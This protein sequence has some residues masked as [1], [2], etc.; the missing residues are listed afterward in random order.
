MKVVKLYEQIPKST[1]PFKLI[2]MVSLEK[3]AYL[4]EDEISIDMFSLYF[5]M[6]FKKKLR[7]KGCICQFI[8]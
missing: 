6:C 3:C 1:C 2:D 7:K 4:P 5:K 8:Q